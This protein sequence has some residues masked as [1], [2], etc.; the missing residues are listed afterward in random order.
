MQE[1]VPQKTAAMTQLIS[2]IH[3]RHLRRQAITT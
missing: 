2:P 1:V 3:S